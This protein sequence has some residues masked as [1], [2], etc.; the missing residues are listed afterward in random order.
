MVDMEDL[1]GLADEPLDMDGLSREIDKLTQ[2]WLAARLDRDRPYDG[3]PHTD[4]GERGRQE[5][6]GIT[7]RDVTDCF[8]RALYDSVPDGAGADSVY[9][10]DLNEADPIAISQNLTCWIERYMGIFPNIQGVRS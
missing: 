2:P 7:M 6:H 3:Q 4:L 1:G 5:V 10:L 8:V 9:D